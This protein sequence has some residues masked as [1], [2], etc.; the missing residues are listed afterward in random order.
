ML[1]GNWYNFET[2]VF[3]VIQPCSPLEVYQRFGDDFCLHHRGYNDIHNGA[4]RKH[5]SKTSVKFSQVTRCNN[6]KDN[7]LY[8]R[9]LENLINSHV[10]F[11]LLRSCYYK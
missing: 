2:A 1:D 3:W 7:H 10:I 8:T 5:L 11:L 6:P 4:G 9:H